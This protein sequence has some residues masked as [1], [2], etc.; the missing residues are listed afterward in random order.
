MWNS[1]YD[2]NGLAGQF[3]EMKSALSLFSCVLMHWSAQYL[4][5]TCHDHVTRNQ[6]VQHPGLR[7]LSL[8]SSI[9]F[10]CYFLSN[11][12]CDYCT[13]SLQVVSLKHAHFCQSERG[14]CEERAWKR[15]R[16]NYY[17]YHYYLQTLTTRDCKRPQTN[18]AKNVG[19]VKTW[20]A[21][22]IM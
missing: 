11:K 6:R 18:M 1:H 14:A 3:W 19:S 22:I 8:S 15:E 10:F 5:A 16:K 13:I 20:S 2:G 12:I 9:Y 7:L 17:Y 4:L 21:K